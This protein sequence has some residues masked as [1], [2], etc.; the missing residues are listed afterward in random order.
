MEDWK[1]DIKEKEEKYKEYIK[2]I[3]KL[4]MTEAEWTRQAEH[5]KDGVEM[6]TFLRLGIIKMNTIIDTAIVKENISTTSADFPGEAA[7]TDKAVA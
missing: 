7:N 2:E 3:A 5:A 4:G 1:E 6:E